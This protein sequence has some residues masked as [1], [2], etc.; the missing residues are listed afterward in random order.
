[1][2]NDYEG[3]MAPDQD[4]RLAVHTD[5][6][7]VNLHTLLASPVTVLIGLDDTG[8]AVLR[9][10]DVHSVMDLAYARPFRVADELVAAAAD[11]DHPFR[12][13]G[14]VP[15]EYVDA[16]AAAN[17]ARW[18]DL[19]LGQL[20]DLPAGAAS[21]VEQ[22]LD[23]RTI[24]DLASFGPYRNARA[25]VALLMRGG[26][27]AA[28]HDPESPADL[29]PKNGEYPTDR[30]YYKNIFVRDLGLR[31]PGVDLVAHGAV[32]LAADAGNIP[33]SVGYGAIVT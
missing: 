21:R 28:E 19:P 20:Q 13:L 31:G 25:L 18:P 11:S 22:A 27:V 8:A 1:M 2:M 29:V 5:Y 9:S 12:R 23:V 33:A 3:A 10:M 14:R 30:V 16:S 24:G 4:P 6:R 7:D 17:V 15:A 32:D 26:V